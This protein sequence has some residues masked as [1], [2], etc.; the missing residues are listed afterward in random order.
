MQSFLPDVFISAPELSWL[1]DH[2]SIRGLNMKT[3][4]SSDL[5]IIIKPFPIQL[6]STI[7]IEE[8]PFLN[9]PDSPTYIG[10]MYAASDDRCHQARTIVIH[11]S[12]KRTVALEWQSSSLRHSF[13][14]NLFWVIEPE[15][16]FYTYL[17]F[18]N[19]RGRKKTIAEKTCKLDFIKFIILSI[20]DIVKKL[21]GQ[22]IDWTKY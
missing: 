21:K 15:L 14:P 5:I 3:W 2:W 8:I 1:T 13:G 18:K 20:K 17:K 10:N 16:Q 6:G 7:Q 4:P 22:I 12:A 19:K 11:R 9:C